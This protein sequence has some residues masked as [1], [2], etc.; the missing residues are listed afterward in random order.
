MRYYFY[1]HNITG[2]YTDLLGICAVVQAQRA[3]EANSIMSALGVD[4]NAGYWY[5]AEEE[6]GHYTISDALQEVK[7]VTAR[8]PRE[9]AFLI[10]NDCICIEDIVELPT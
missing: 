7:T 1:K 2:G 9:K 4:F 3:S 6:D 5:L 10:L 8:W